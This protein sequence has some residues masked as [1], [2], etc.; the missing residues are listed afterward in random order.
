MCLNIFTADELQEISEWFLISGKFTGE[1][2]KWIRFGLNKALRDKT[3]FVVVKR[4]SKNALTVNKELLGLTRDQV[5]KNKM[6]TEGL[7]FEHIV[8][9]KSV[10]ER[11]L[12]SKHINEIKHI[13]AEM[14]VVWI[15]NEENNA[16]K[17][18]GFHIKERETREKADKAY[19]ICGIELIK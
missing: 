7:V 3:D 17:T 6:N 5:R 11:C 2:S 14:E 16:L 1:G 18:K 13:L 12:N 10:V 9:L 8:P 19:N 15:T 4:I